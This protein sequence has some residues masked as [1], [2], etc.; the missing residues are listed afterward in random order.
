M[1]DMFGFELGVDRCWD[2]PEF[3][4]R[5]PGKDELR[6]VVHKQT[7][8]RSVLHT[9]IGQRLSNTPNLL[10]QVVIRPASPFELERLVRPDFSSNCVGDMHDV[11]K[12]PVIVP[13]FLKKPLTE[14]LS[15]PCALD[16]GQVFAY[17]EFRI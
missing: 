11:V 6:R 7:H 1:S 8:H 14:L 3:E 13:V 17:R 15:S 12:G 4:Q 16:L 10:S 5:P 9:C 2:S